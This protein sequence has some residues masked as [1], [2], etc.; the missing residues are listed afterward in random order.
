MTK[1]AALLLAIGFACGAVLYGGIWVYGDG[2]IFNRFSGQVIFVDLPVDE[3]AVRLPADLTPPPGTRNHSR[4]ASAGHGRENGS[5]T[6]PQR[7]A[8][9]SA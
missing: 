9:C 1:G 3:D 5:G 6:S 2:F 4:R 7:P 8:P